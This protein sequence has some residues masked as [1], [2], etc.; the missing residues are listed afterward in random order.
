[1][2]SYFTYAN[3]YLDLI[4]SKLSNFIP[5]R[6]YL[7]DYPNLNN[8]YKIMNVSFL[9]N[10]LKIFYISENKIIL[11]LI[12]NIVGINLENKIIRINN[13]DQILLDYKKRVMPVIPKFI[14]ESIRL[15]IVN[16]RYYLENL[17]NNLFKIDRDTPI[18]F[19]LA[20]YEMINNINSCNITLKIHSKD[21][22]IREISIKI[23]E[24]DTINN[25]I[26]NT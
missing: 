17:K 22:L 10:L 15:D 16:H 5:F 18:I 2:I 25:I 4:K 14:I 7:I 1:M 26:K 11:D 13:D 20:H 12:K 21:N 9:I 6:Y 8:E 24:K 3:I 23:D 19:C